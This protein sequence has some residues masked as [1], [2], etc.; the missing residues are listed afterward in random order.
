M[1][2]ELE[3]RG[4]VV[5][6]HVG[7][8]DVDALATR[9]AIGFLADG[10][11]WATATRTGGAVECG[12]KECGHCVCGSLVWQAIEHGLRM[13]R[14]LDRAPGFGDTPSGSIRKVLRS[15]ADVFAAVEFFSA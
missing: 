12:E 15:I 10:Q 11:R 2:L 7:I 4:R 13:A 6:Q 8:E 3:Q 9:H 5:H 1:L 14:D